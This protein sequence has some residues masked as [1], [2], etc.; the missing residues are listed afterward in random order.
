VT[1]RVE[2]LTLETEAQ[3]LF[4]A[5]GGFGRGLERVRLPEDARRPLHGRRAPLIAWAVSV[6][7]G[8]SLA[9]R[10]ELA[11]GLGGFDEALD[12]GE[13]L[14]VEATTICSGAS[15]NPGTRSSTSR[16]PSR[17]TS[18]AATPPPWPRRSP[19]TS[20]LWWRSSSRS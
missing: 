7:S 20:G 13:V 17:A 11:L 1:G 4:E 10:R 6:G 19:G 9:V 16:P 15:W 8:C 14:P 5:N 2:A 12:L 18:T 3:R